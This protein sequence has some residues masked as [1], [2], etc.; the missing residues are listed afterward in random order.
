VTDIV[1]AHQHFWDPATGDYPWM[2]DELAAI[3]RRFAPDDLRPI[4]ERRGV[5]RTI[6]V[7]TRSSLPE[8][9]EFLDTAAS[10]DFVAGVVGWIDLTD[11]AIVDVLDR[12]RS[13]PTGRW[14]VG[15]RHQTHDE[16]DPDWLTRPDVMR[17]LRAVARAGLPYDLVIRTRELPASLE[18]AT[19][20]PELALVVDHIA[21]PDIRHG[22]FEPWAER[23]AA[24]AAMPNVT[25][26]VSGMVT[27][28]DW[29]TWTRAEL[30]PYVD[31]VLGWFGPRRLLFGSDWPVCLLAAT[32]DEVLDAAEELFG[33]LTA[34]ERDEVFEGTATRVYGL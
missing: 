9:V 30:R 16:P 12:L 31:L 13:G 22:L 20:I 1:D 18:I 2:T 14:L 27:E 17:G 10:I 32:Y 24:L 6:L 26:K 15:I 21:K 25:C 34:A 3:R 33:G 23:M 8:T 19:R 29:S 7:Q 4:V 5:T 28:A 11:E